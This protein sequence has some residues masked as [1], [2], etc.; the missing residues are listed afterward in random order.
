MRRSAKVSRGIQMKKPISAK[1]ASANPT[2]ETKPAVAS[3]LVEP[4]PNSETISE[5]AIRLGAYRHWVTAGK[6]SGDGVNFWLE[7]KSEF[8][9]AK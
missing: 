6:P 2:S 5:E 4:S 1:P 3:V 8:S 7:A 9:Q